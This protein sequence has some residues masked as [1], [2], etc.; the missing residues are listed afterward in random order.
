MKPDFKETEDTPQ[1]LDDLQQRSWE[2]EVLLSGI[3]LFGM[4]KVPPLLDQ[5]LVFFKSQ[6]FG[7]TT[8]VDNFVGIL[9]LGI[10][11]LIVGLILHL[12]CR[13]IWVGMVG[14]SYSFPNGV[15]AGKL[16]FKHRFKKRV[17]K[18][19]PFQVLIIKLEKLCSSLFS[20]SFM[21]FM[22]L[23]GAYLYFFILLI[24]PFIFAVVLQG[25][26]NFTDTFAFEVYVIIVLVVA[27]LGLLDFL[28][29]GFFRRFSIVARV[30]WPVHYFVSML[31][32]GRYY[33]P[34]YFAFVSSTRRW[35]IFLVLASFVFGS[36]F[37]LDQIT[38]NVYDG[39]AFS[40]LSLW[41]ARDMELRIYSGY[42]EDQ[43]EEFY[44]Y[45]AQIPSDIIEGNVLRL[46][47]PVMIGKEDSIM[48]YANYD[49]LVLANEGMKKGARD[50]SAIK[51]FYHVYLD[52]SLIADL[53]IFYH[54][55]LSTNQPGYLMYIDISSLTQGMHILD[56][57]GPPTMYRTKW[58]SIPFF[59]EQ[60]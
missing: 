43:N 35:I 46:F 55:R 53:P 31:T 14:L 45:Q 25:G 12:I 22:S 44:S 27:V 54:Y 4:F 36:F 49:S 9:K 34:I 51:K 42:Y 58:A 1:W 5:A 50:L 19:P 40:R 47:I 32:L 2:P 28:T 3:V 26:D 6:V 16:Q 37:S 20:L 11:W 48:K 18:I 41:H 21:L 10:Y 60:D 52:D 30:Y 56:V 39:S 7:S 23:V 15:N 13:G 17:E 38:G 29:L 8:D 57:G 33:R 59:R 24:V